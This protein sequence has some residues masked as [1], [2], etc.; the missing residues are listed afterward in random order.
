MS[1]DTL[2][3]VSC[4]NLKMWCMDV[5]MFLPAGRCEPGWC[6]SSPAAASTSHH[7]LTTSNH[8]QPQHQPLT[9][10]QQQP[11]ITS[12]SINL[13]PPVNNSPSSPAATTTSHH[14]STTANHHQLQHQPLTTC[15]Q[16][17]S[18]KVHE[19]IYNDDLWVRRVLWS[20]HPAE[21]LLFL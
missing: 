8:H 18:P 2:L 17:S 9:P 10:C 12:R 6:L 3:S 13:S 15:Q 16:Q 4:L 19:Y 14:L 20:G 11:I 7:L 1:N 5:W 21:S